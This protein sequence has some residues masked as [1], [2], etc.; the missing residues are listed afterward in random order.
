[1][2]PYIIKGSFAQLWEEKKSKDYLM[3]FWKTMILR[4]PI[5]KFLL[6]AVASAWKEEP[7]THWQ[8]HESNNL[9]PTLIYIFLGFGRGHLYS[10]VKVE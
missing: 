5:V 1:M 10:S 6:Y 9:R 3:G 2:E 4:C 7:K 8:N